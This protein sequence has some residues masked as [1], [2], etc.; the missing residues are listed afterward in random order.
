MARR[1][2]VSPSKTSV[3]V[4]LFEKTSVNGLFD[5]GRS[6]NIL[7]CAIPNQLNLFN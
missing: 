1:Y 6:H 3:D 2:F 5:S 7:A 4:T